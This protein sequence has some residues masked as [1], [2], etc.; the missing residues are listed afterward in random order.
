MTGAEMQA[1]YFGPLAYA[2]YLLAILGG[3]II[4]NL[5]KWSKICQTK[6]QV[7]VR[8]SDG[9]GR[10]ELAPK[11]GSC[12]SLK[13]PN[14]NTIRLWP[15]NELA[16]IDVPYPGLGFI[17]ALLQKQIRMVVVDEDDWE[18]LL[19]RS[20]YLSMVAS[21]DVKGMLEAIAER[22]PN[23]NTKREITALSE[24]LSSA[25]TREMIASPSVLG[26]LVHEKVTEVVMT[27]NKDIIESLAS[28]TKKLNS[29]LSPM[30]FIV[31]I[32][33]LGIILA[34]MSFK[35]IPA[36]DKVD[37]MN[38]RIEVIQQS[39]GISTNPITPRN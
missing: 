15:I 32:A 24:D 18:P 31:G 23:E 29:V 25:P 3:L 6:V 22:C 16:T 26:N 9:H 30:Q 11:E 14:N 2:F 10:F 7:L 1:T 35:I 19:N 21:P 36:M 20:P 8:K 4:Y 33:I 27:I 17:P 28:L 5:Y 12:V 39:L 38:N 13:N 37:T 34:V